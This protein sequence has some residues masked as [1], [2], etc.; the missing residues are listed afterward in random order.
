MTE[1]QI[2]REPLQIPPQETARGRSTLLFQPENICICI[3]VAT[4]VKR[5]Q[6][7]IRIAPTLVL[8]KQKNKKIT[9]HLRYILYSCFKVGV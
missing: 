6:T 2:V 9:N 7:S 8:F 1:F 5:P 3:F 4:I